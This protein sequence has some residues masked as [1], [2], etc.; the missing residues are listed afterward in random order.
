MKQECRWF[1]YDW[2]FDGEPAVFGVASSMRFCSGQD[3]P[4]LLTLLFSDSK[5][6]V[7]SDKSFNKITACINK[8]CGIWFKL[9]ES[10]NNGNFIA[11]F[12]RTARI[13]RVYLYFNDESEC[14]TL[15]RLIMKRLHF[16]SSNEIFI[17]SAHETFYNLLSPDDAKL[18]TVN[19]AELINSLRA[20]GDNAAPRRINLHLAFKNEPLMLSFSALALKEGF[21]IGLQEQH[22]NDELPCG[23]V[24]HRICALR[25]QDI[26][27]LTTNSI[28]LA[29]G[30]EGKLLYWDCP[31]VLSMK[32][33]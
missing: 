1:E 31:L 14:N 16:S 20:G 15:A 7:L 5:G 29:S 28:M 18:Q 19:N 12:V 26:D 32:R 33:H 6:K 21:A 2:Q 3:H 24:L 27:N 22:E 8:C 9:S 11:G 25:K 23:I 4:A 30:F 17:E 13:L 10:G